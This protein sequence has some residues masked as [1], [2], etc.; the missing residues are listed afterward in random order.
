M[1]NGSRRGLGPVHWGVLM[2]WKPKRDVQLR[3][4][5]GKDP[6]IVIAWCWGNT[7]ISKDP[8]PPTPCYPTIQ[9][10]IC[11]RGFCKKHP[12]EEE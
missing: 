8:F 5:S 12:C 10:T 6:R 4:E 9:C 7:T 2:Q 1:M 3:E 11:S